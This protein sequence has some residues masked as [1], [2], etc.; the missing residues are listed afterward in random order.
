MGH[1]S[2]IQGDLEE[3]RERE[4]ERC[5]VTYLQVRD[6]RDGFSFLCSHVHE[7]VGLDRYLGWL[8]YKC[9]PIPNDITSNQ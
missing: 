2:G 9:G 3:L 1:I 5:M 4:R 8:V 6:N 7:H